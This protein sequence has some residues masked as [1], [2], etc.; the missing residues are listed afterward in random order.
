MAGPLIDPDSCYPEELADTAVQVELRLASHGVAAED[1]QRI[2]WEMAEHLRH[3]W[4][5]HQKFL[6]IQRPHDGDQLDL[7]GSE[8][9]TMPENPILADLAEQVGERLVGIGQAPAEAAAIGLDVA[10]H[11]HRHWGTGEIYICKGLRYEITLRDREIYRRSNGRNYEW[12][13]TEYNLTVQ[14][15]YRVVKRVGAIE[16]A[17]RQCPL[18]PADE[19]ADQ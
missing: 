11:I 5:G 13:A 19:H 4:G 1:A 7:L 2:A 12:L 3:R 15:V 16:R 14:H 17:K 8:G 10:G 6:R 9:G 18:F